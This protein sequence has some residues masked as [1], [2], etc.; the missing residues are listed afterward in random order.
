MVVLLFESGPKGGPRSCWGS[1]EKLVGAPRFELGT[2][3]TPCKCATRLRHAPTRFVL[4]I[5][6]AAPVPW[7]PGM[8]HTRFAPACSGG[9]APSAAQDAHHVFEFGAQLAHDLLALGN[10]RACFVAGEL[11]ARA[12]DREALL[13]QKT[14]YLPDDDHVL[15]LIVAAVAA[16]FDRLELRKLLFPVTQHMRLDAAQLTHLADGE[17]ALAGNRRQLVVIPCFQHRLRRVL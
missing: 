8:D 17:I 11:V 5:T 10:V 1:H 15:A 13:V 4:F 3:C 16:A 9:G 6:T 2:P 7:R 14:A 12:A